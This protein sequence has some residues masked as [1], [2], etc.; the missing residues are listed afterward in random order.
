MKNGLPF[1]AIVFLLPLSASAQA[2]R[3]E[4]SG[5]TRDA[6]TD[7]RLP[8][9][10]VVLTRLADTTQVVGTST[11]ARGFF[12]LNVPAMG[13]YRIQFTFVGYASKQLAID[14]PA[15]GFNLG[16]VA[17]EEGTVALDEVVVEDVQQRVTVK[18]DTT[19]YNAGAFKTNPDASAEDLVGKM[20]GVQV[21]DG[22][23]QVQGENVRR[24]LVDGREF[25]GEDPTAALRNL[26]AEVIERIQV[27]DRLSDQAQFSGFNDGNTERTIN[28]I[29]RTGTENGQFGKVYGGYGPDTRYIAGG[30][31]NIFDGDRRIS[32]IG[33]SN[34][35]NQQNFSNEDILGVIGNTGR[36]NF[37]GFGGPGG[38][39]GFGGPGGGGNRGGGGGGG[40]NRG[41]GGGGSFGG[42]GGGFGGPDAGSFLVGNQ[43]G[44]NATNA[45]G[46]NFSDTWGEK[47]RFTGSYFFNRSDNESNVLLDREYFLTADA[48]QLYNESSVTESD[49]MNHRVNVRLAYDIDETNA[50]IFTPRFS[51]QSN[52][53]SN[54]LQGANS[55]A[56]VALSTTTN[57]YVSENR[58]LSSNSNLLFRH[59]F[60]KAGRTASVNFGLGLNDRN[61]NAE[62]LATNEY[63]DVI[64]SLIVVDQRSRNTETGT[65]L[66]A[67]VEYTEPIGGRGQLQVN[68]SPSVTNSDA[69]RTTNTRD[70]VTGLYTVIDPALS[71]VFDSR[72]V[73]QRGGLRYIIRG[74]KAMFSTGI[75]VQNVDLSGNQTFPTTYGVERTFQDVLPQAMFN[76]QFSRTDNLRIFYRTNT[77]TPSISQLQSVI[78]NTNPLRITSGNPELRQSY[79]HFVMAR[80]NK[81][82]PASGRVFMMFAS[83][84]QSQNNIGTESILALRDTTI[85]P[86]VV[87]AQGSQYSR[88]V[89]L[90][91]FWSARSFMTAGLPTGVLKSNVNVN[92]GYSLTH[93][94]G[95]LNG[96]RNVSDTHTITGGA[97]IGSNISEKVDFTF[98]YALNYNISRNTVYTDLDANYL[99]HRT[100]A[101][102]NLLF[103]KSWVF[104]T[105]LNAIQYSGL[106]E[107]YDQDNLVWNAGFGYKFLKGNGGEVRLMVADILDQNNSVVR[108]VNEFYVEDN[109]SNVLGRYVLLN[110]TYRLR[111]FGAQAPAVPPRG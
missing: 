73:R 89:N 68:Y 13:A 78:D 95:L 45:F 42:P 16:F 84:N 38:Q 26:P 52:D 4:V 17:L 93:S 39:G 107:A 91:G 105:D 67:N 53:A 98:T 81:T 9:V 19:E 69:D 65:T 82:V 70:S 7:E 80:F 83:M 79:S 29:T 48:T 59:R 49:N 31:M 10:N 72:S 87:L 94:P 58:G 46:L 60:P 97:V 90:D 15:A 8:A 5:F 106:G 50:I 18:G 111:N 92:A 55:L 71:T 102:I 27:Y 40:G 51:F 88:P 11:N 109:R 43:G 61:G 110:F 101:R 54:S 14:V 99:Y 35:V 6:K 104:N 56:G 86:G 103:G 23:V 1:L 44:I 34:N 100:G 64:D 41:G 62:Q 74:E 75:D 108:T 22:Q 37:G 47:V 76:Y 36:N 33:L 21:Q 20:P 57:D 63:F 85:A 77:N 96:I 3:P 66:S 30:N 12:S 32:I 25:F 2:V 24:V 28:I